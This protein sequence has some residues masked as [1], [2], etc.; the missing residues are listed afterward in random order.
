MSPMSLS[1]VLL[2]EFD[3]EAASTRRMLERVPTS[4]LDFAPPPSRSPSATA[5]PGC[6][7]TAS[8]TDLLASTWES[9]MEKPIPADT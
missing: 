7:F 1:E 2:A 3:V 4:S 6:C 9:G 8:P 5:S